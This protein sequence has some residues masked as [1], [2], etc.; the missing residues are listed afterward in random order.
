MNRIDY[1]SLI[2]TNAARFVLEVEGYT[3]I[4][5]YHIN[6]H[7][8]TFIIPVLNKLYNLSLKNLNTSEKKNYPAID[9]ADFDNKI[10]FQISSTSTQSKIQETLRTYKRHE[11]YKEFDKIYFYFLTDK[12]QKYNQKKLNEITED[13]FEFDCA[14]QILDK[15]RILEKINSIED[16]QLIGQ[17]AKIY[18]HDFSDVQIDQRKQKYKHGYLNT[19]P[20]P[21][22]ANLLEVEI[23]KVLYQA[24][25]NIDEETITNDLNEYLISIGKKPI[26]K[27]K[28]NK[29][30][31]K[32]L[33]RANS[34]VKDWVLHKNLII[35][36]RNPH[37]GSDGLSKIIDKGTIEEYEVSDF[38]NE[39]EA[40][41]N[42]FKSL[43]Q[44]TL[45]ELCF[46][47]EIE[48]YNPQNIYR[49]ANN[50]IAPNKKRVKWKGKKE[51]TKTVI[52]EIINK[53]EGHIVC[54]R[55]LAFKSNFINVE[56]NWYL[57]INPTWSFTNP[58][59]YKPSRYES[60]Y[61]S[62]LKRLE[63]NQTVFNYFRFFAFYLS[64]SDLFNPQYKYL[65]I[66]RPV[67]LSLSP[68]LD[69][70]KWKPEKSIQIEIDNE[71]I[72]ID[73]DKEIIDL[74]LFD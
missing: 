69:E 63:N 72:D 38:Y 40:S 5:T 53:K 74:T 33:K 36:F 44:K 12:K 29:L 61:M 49:F 57:L 7:A 27:L 25:L 48:F 67:E 65:K 14:T 60:S 37:D 39:S 73:E 28:P 13:K 47:K 11:L 2:N 59:G 56:K 4:G 16:S 64:S 52:F 10:A 46:N 22:A 34:N 68:Q 66:N 62:G 23:P 20:E 8:E 32:A 58:G 43:L 17:I 51:A 15:D 70:K 54:F 35:S 45:T 24:E 55:S 31:R 1:I 41:K 71:I 6:I 50:Q 21:I 42:V 9:L 3:A 26:K 19:D 30:V 18:K